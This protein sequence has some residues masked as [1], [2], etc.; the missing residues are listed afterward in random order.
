MMEE[1]NKNTLND[2]LKQLPDYSPKDEL[3]ESLE[4][5]LNTEG[6]INHQTLVTS[7]RRLPVFAAPE[8]I[9]QKI[10]TQ[11]SG[12]K[13]RLFTT[14]RLAAAV[15]GLIIIGAGIWWI[16]GSGT[17]LSGNPQTYSEKS[18]SAPFPNTEAEIAEY[19]HQLAEQEEELLE[20]IDQ[21]PERESEKIQP[22]LDMLE[23]ITATRDSMIILLDQQS[24][25]G[26]LRRLQSL[27]SRRKEL[28]GELKATACSVSE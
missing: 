3:W 15:T 24:H 25:P 28:I 22:V 6:E 10:E 26:T 1:K 16:F 17:G 4:E 11:L 12:R 5:K 7:I 20:C 19:D 9:W 14:G 2:A 23:S 13:I 21:L 18:I 8:Q 27:E